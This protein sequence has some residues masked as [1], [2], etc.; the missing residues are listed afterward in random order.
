MFLKNGLYH[1]QEH[2]LSVLGMSMCHSSG[3]LQR[4]ERGLH[5]SGAKRLQVNLA[6]P[7][8]QGYDQLKNS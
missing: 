4:H 8:N 7:Q 5:M 1:M 6:G 2:L 3:H